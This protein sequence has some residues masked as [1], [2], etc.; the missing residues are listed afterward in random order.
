MPSRNHPNGANA[1]TTLF[2]ELVRRGLPAGYARRTAE[3][4]EDH[5]ADLLVDLSS[6]EEADERLGDLGVLARSIA[7]DYRRRSWFGRWPVLSFAVL[8]PLLLAASWAG[9]AL[10]LLGIG[11]L[12]TWSGGAS[13][14]LWSPVEHA[15]VAWAFTLGLFA[16]IVPAGVAWSCSRLALRRS[17]S[18]AFVMTACLGIGLLNS[19]PHHD[20]RVDP[21]DPSLAMNLISVPFCDPMDPVS[22]VACANQLTKP[23]ILCQLLAPILVGLLVVLHDAR[24]RRTSL[25]APPAPASPVP[26]AA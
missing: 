20:Y 2:A 11:E 9:V 25:L 1:E 4:I 24:R 14:E 21:A 22:L 7:R 15:R 13:G 17:P 19:L 12:W 6:A 5:R 8:P 26:I 16:F 18:R 3:E 10:A 23:I